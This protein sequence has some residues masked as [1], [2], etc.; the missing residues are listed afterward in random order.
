MFYSKFQTRQQRSEETDCRIVCHIKHTAA[1]QE[2]LHSV[3]EQ[4]PQARHGKTCKLHATGR[5]DQLHVR[6]S[7]SK[8]LSAQDRTNLT[9]AS[10]PPPSAGVLALEPSFK[11][12]VGGL[13]MAAFACNAK[14]S[15]SWA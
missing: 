5:S 13:L 10:K 1:M 15:S 7:L 14:E 6:S 8:N 4:V 2:Q 11:V 9:S 12:T 3:V